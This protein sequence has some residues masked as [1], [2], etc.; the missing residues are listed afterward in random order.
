MQELTNIPHHCRNE[1]K[2]P[3]NE[4]LPGLWLLH[5]TDRLK[6]HPFTQKYTQYI[7]NN[8]LKDTEGYGQHSRYV[9]NKVT[10]VKDHEI[11]LILQTC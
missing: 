5:S 10:T 8:I 3:D 4:N 1:K 6:V 2:Q 9:K 7:Q 11:C